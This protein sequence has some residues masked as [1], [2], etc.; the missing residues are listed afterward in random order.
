MK[1]A[2]R[3]SPVKNLSR[4]RKG[5]WI[6]ITLKALLHHVSVGR[7]RKGA[8]IEIHDS[9]TTY[10]PPQGRSRKGAWI[11]MLSSI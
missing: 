10:L 4:S 8:W 5:A 6:E 3:M 2:G 9:Y 11:E 7:S 1:S